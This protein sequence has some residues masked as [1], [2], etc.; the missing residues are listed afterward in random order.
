MYQSKVEPWKKMLIKNF[1]YLNTIK[2]EEKVIVNMGRVI[3]VD[4]SSVGKENKL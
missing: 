1:I 2:S 4:G 3:P